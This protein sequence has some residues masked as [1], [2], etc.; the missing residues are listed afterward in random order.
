MNIEIKTNIREI[1][2]GLPV[3]ITNKDGRWYILAFNEAGHN[4]VEIDLEDVIDW[5]KEN[6]IPL[7]IRK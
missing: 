2:E 6:A 3:T 4:G 5:Y 1:V 7:E